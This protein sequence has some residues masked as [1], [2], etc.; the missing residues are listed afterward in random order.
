MK[1]DERGSGT[2][3]GTGLNGI[4]E[5]LG[6]KGR[7]SLVLLGVLY[8]ICWLIII[9]CNVFGD[10]VI[11]GRIPTTLVYVTAALP[12]VFFA[13]LLLAWGLNY[14]FS[15]M[16]RKLSFPLFVL[17]C[18]VLWLVW[19][20]GNTLA[21]LYLTSSLWNGWGRMIPIILMLMTAGYAGVNVRIYYMFEKGMGFR[22]YLLH[23][24]ILAFSAGGLSLN[25]YYNYSALFEVL[26]IP[27]SVV[28]VFSIFTLAQ[29][30]IYSILALITTVGMYLEI[31][32]FKHKRL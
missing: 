14:F 8:A 32:K 23:W 5:K 12:F 26:F 19:T 15:L 25:K 21:C 1:Q 9:I 2:K 18:L 6:I 24:S 27:G 22:Y 3:Q 16:F 30:F 10:G 4:F 31:E 17:F 29:L 20:Y 13:L 11:I 7:R 28:E